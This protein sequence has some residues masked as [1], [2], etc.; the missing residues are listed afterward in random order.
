MARNPFIDEPPPPNGDHGVSYTLPVLTNDGDIITP[1]S[2]GGTGGLWLM[3]FNPEWLYETGRK[4]DFSSGAEGWSTFGTKG[5]EVVA[6]PD[7]PGRRA[8]QLRK[9]E[10]DWP[11]AAVWNFPNGMNGRL[12]I[13][14][15]V[16]PGFAGTRIGLTD[17][18]SV[19]FDPEDQNYN[20][21]NL[22]IGPKGKIGRDAMTVAQW[23]TLDL[24]WSVAKDECRVFV[25]GRHVDTL[26]LQRRTAGVNYLRLSSIVEGIDL[27]GLLIESV[28]A[29]LF[30]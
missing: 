8:L 17:H 5:V 12:R 30:E 21:F 9:P 15:K 18:F 1:L 7:K 19:P 4:T 26:P 11:S 3:R 14:L 13:R 10:A 6:N 16:N 28:D 24:N 2:V 23:H 20:L 22:S 27:A 29:S 25:D